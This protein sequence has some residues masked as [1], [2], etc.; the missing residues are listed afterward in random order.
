MTAQ[1]SH[2]CRVSR[3]KYRA[4][5]S[6]PRRL[7][8]MPNEING[9]PAHVLSVHAVVVFITLTALCVAVAA[10]WPRA[11]RWLGPLPPVLALVCVATAYA[12]TQAGEW[13]ADR[14]GNPPFIREHAELGDQMPWWALGLFIAATGQWVWH[15]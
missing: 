13:L 3:S 7:S 14:L 11:R 9:I 1:P 5:R 15:R 8:A 4:T 6:S 12:A 2:R 10:W